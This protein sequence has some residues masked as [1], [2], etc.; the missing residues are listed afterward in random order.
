MEEK[1]YYLTKEGLERIKKEYEEMKRQRRDKLKKESPEIL[2]SEDVNPEYLAFRRDLAIL[3][4]NISKM[5]K[6]L[7]NAELIE[8]PKKECKDIRLG[9]LIT[10]ETNGRVEEFTLVGTMEADP[11]IGKISDESP[12][13]KALLGKKE[14]EEVTISSSFTT[15]YKIKKVCYK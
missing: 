6:V 7:R 1:R 13:G 15:V 2:H 12:I 5:E 11:N 9:A 14:G 8:P 3:E 4:E 10:M